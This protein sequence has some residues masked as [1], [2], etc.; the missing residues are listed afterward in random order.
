M[1][2]A[3]GLFKGMSSPMAGVAVINAMIFGVYGNVQRRMEDPTSLKS[4]A[5]AGAV[6]GL[7]QSVISSPMELVKTRIQVQG[8][9]VPCGVAPYSGPA[10]CLRQIWRG[11]GWRGVFRGLGVTVAREIPAFAV[12]FAS[13]EAMTR[14][15]DASKPIGTAHMMLAGG[16]AGMFSWLLTYP[17]DVVKSRLQV[18]FASFGG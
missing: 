13:F 9:S 8:Q 4:H 3:R 2:Q 6:A 5:V 14:Q 10:D 16:M 15:D 17:I 18:N 7:S 1:I 11:E 12:Y